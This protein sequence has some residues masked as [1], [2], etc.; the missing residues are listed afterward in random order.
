VVDAMAHRQTLQEQSD[1]VLHECRMVLPGVQTV[2]GF[3]LIAVF[4]P[5]FAREVSFFDRAL[6]VASMG[7]IATAVV[8]LMLPAAYRRL[9]EPG[10]V[11]ER[12]VPIGSASIAVGLAALALG[13]AL[14]LYIVTRLALGM[15]AVAITLAVIVSVLASTAWFGVPLVMRGK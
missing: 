10:V 12:F 1:A 14:D 4:Q 13:L 11:T 5:T 15:P 2:L 9:G 8:C 6:H 7:S 3:Q